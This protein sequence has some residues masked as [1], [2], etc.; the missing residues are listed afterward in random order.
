MKLLFKHGM[1][2]K[3]TAF[4]RMLD[5]RMGHLQVSMAHHRMNMDHRYL[6]NTV[7]RRIV[8]GHQHHH[9]GRLQRRL[10]VLRLQH[11]VLHQHPMGRLHSASHP[12]ALMAKD[13]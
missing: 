7:H 2:T 1:N 6:V 9:M 3:I 12:M 5:I 4:H 10:M 8:M 11:M 13:Q